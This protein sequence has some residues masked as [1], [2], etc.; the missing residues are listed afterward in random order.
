MDDFVVYLKAEFLD[1]VYLQQ[2]AFD[3]VDG[4]TSA[5]RQRHVFAR[6]RADPRG[7]DWTSRTRTRRAGSSRR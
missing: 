2:N 3:A 4:A 6:D 1:A 7:A 5:E